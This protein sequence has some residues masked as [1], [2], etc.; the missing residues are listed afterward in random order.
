MHGKGFKGLQEQEELLAP[1]AF[2]L[3]KLSRLA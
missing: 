3:G 2:A 1:T